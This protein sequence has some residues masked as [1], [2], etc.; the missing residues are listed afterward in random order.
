MNCEKVSAA[1]QE[2]YDEDLSA[3][4]KIRMEEHLL[5]CG[6][7]RLEIERWRAL[8]GLLRQDAVSPPNAALDRKVIAA[9]RQKHAADNR[10]SAWWRAILVG[11]VSVPKP[12]FAAALI[13]AVIA[14]AAAHLIGRN[15]ATKFAGKIDSSDS[16]AVSPAPQPEI[17]ERT[18]IVEIPIERVVTK[19]VYVE[20][21]N[22]VASAKNE[23]KR[24]TA[25][26]KSFDRKAQNQTASVNDSN[27]PLDGSI[28]QNG[29]FTPVNLKNFQPAE[30]KT[31]IIKE[32]KA[33]EK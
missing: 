32:V 28:A 17:I 27:L 1:A 4:E 6:W 11:S 33:D 24:T 20:R 25:E 23:K 2:F 5:I 10:P 3:Q 19:T 21:E 13:V 12:A 7:C 14:V 9:F 18:K 16:V 15:E 30:M 29:Y 26:R 22:Y 31:R 8:S